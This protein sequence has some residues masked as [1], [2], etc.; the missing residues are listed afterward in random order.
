MR[1]TRQPWFGPKRGV[2][3]GWRPVT[4]QG[5]LIV[6]VFIALVVASGLVFAGATAFVAVVV[7]VVVLIGV[8]AITG[9][10]PG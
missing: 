5:W 6:A 2:G 4:W 1:F 10:A 9:D 3:W 7:L 8:C